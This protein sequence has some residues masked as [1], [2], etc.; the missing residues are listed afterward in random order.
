MRKYLIPTMLFI[1]IILFSDPRSMYH[2][3]SDAL[4]WREMTTILNEREVKTVRINN[5]ELNKGSILG[6]LGKSKF[7]ESNW[8]QYGPTPEAV[9]TIELE[10]GDR[11]HFGHWGGSTF[12]T[13]YRGHQFLISNKKLGELVKDFYMRRN[14]VG[15]NFWCI[16][17]VYRW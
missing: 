11:L 9:I 1:L 10:K 15:R 13:T 2:N 17:K 5:V 6:E 3:L 14:V 4:A 16:P 8:R 12:E 7:E